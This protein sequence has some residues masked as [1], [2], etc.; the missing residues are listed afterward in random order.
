MSSPSPTP[1]PPSA[2]AS[3]ESLQAQ[4]PSGR[5]LAAGAGLVSAGRMLG[6]VFN[7]LIIV[8]LTR[9]LDPAIFGLVAMVYLIQ[10]TLNS[11]GTLGLPS[12]LFYF[13]PKHGEASARSLGLWTGGLLFLLALP[14]ALTLWLGGPSIAAWTDKPD[15]APAL[16]YLAVYLLADFPGQALP[17]FLLARQ[18]YRAAFG[19]TV[20]FYGGRFLSL[21]VPAALGGSLQTLMI[22][23][24]GVALLRL[25]AFLGYFLLVQRGPWGRSGWSPRQ[26]LAYGVPL[27]LSQIVGKLN[28]QIDK[29]MIAALCSAQVF[30]VY[31]VG[32]IEL[33][34]V[35]AIAYS[36]T[37]ALIPA[38]VLLHGR[39]DS[40]GFLQTWHGSMGKVAAIMMPIF[41][42]FLVMAPAAMRVF[43]SASYGDAAVP[44]RVY[45]LLLPLRLCSYGGVVRALGRTRPVLWASGAA[46]A[47]N[48]LLNYPLYRVLGLPGPALASVLAQLVAIALLLHAVR[49]V[50]GV[51][52]RV[53]F[54]VRRVAHALLVAG[55]AC[56]PLLAVPQWLSGDVLQLSVGAALYLPLYLGLAATTGL[57]GREDFQYLRDVVSLRILRRRAGSEGE[58]GR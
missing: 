34:L 14:L 45:L 36:V 13:V 41:F 5:T 7:L 22:S 10:E 24:A 56:L 42:F 40:Q 39:R 58:S 16:G 29:Y 4:R 38:M 26:L 55:V 54:P 19:V 44:F 53:L 33:P 6:G 8:A 35:A 20:F 37:D 30:A 2:D 52:W 47:A 1:A 21:V 17:N 27:S 50:L 48:A 25:A 57:L 3:A 15:L 49:V 32:A 51:R 23:F 11:I 12:A 46:L 31:T 28:V 18:S 43:F 9:L